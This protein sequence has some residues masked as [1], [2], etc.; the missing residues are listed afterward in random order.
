MLFSLFFIQFLDAIFKHYDTY[1]L[2]HPV[3]WPVIK[4]VN[5]LVKRPKMRIYVDNFRVSIW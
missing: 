1:L 4:S 2:S 3:K 5:L